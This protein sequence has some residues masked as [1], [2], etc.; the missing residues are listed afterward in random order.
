MK[1]GV[2]LA[3]DVGATLGFEAVGGSLTGDVLECM[4]N[5]SSLQV[6][7]ALSGQPSSGLTARNFSFQRKTVS[8]FW[9]GPDKKQRV[10]L[11]W[12]SGGCVHI[13]LAY[14]LSESSRA[15]PENRQ[16]W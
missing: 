13:I 7:G 1:D 11:R 12:V 5:G 3:N 10:C 4:L 14:P 2:A 9:L 6:Y 8:G 15:S 16:I